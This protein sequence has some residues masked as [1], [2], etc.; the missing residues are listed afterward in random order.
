M[1]AIGVV[2]L[3]TSATRIGPLR[4]AVVMNLEPL[5]AIAGSWMVLGQGLTPMQL[6]GGVLVLGGVLGAQ[7]GRGVV[8][9]PIKGE[10]HATR[11]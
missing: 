1:Y 3:F 8:T 6:V 11:R 7:L 9:H 2:S 10:G 5:I 4:T